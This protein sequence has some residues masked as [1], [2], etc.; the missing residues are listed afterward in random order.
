MVKKDPAEFE[1]GGGAGGLH[2]RR[3][4]VKYHNKT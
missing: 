3:F 4:D 2:P 1:G